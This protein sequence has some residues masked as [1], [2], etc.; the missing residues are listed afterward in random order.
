MGFLASERCCLFIYTQSHNIFWAV[1]YFTGRLQ[2]RNRH[3]CCCCC[4]FCCCY[5]M[6]LRACTRFVLKPARARIF[7]RNCETAA[8]TQEP[9]IHIYKL[10][11]PFFVR[12]VYFALELKFWLLYDFAVSRCLFVLGLLFI[13]QYFCLRSVCVSAFFALSLFISLSLSISLR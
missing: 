3:I 10:I 4:W 7:N 11:V 12:F 9:Y 6:L 5:R 8:C 1:A 13:Y 2:L